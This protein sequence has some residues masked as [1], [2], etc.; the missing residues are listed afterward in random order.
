[1]KLEHVWFKGA[2]DAIN[3][4]LSNS[5]PSTILTLFSALLVTTEGF[6][7]VKF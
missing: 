6:G 2:T 5:G 4:L 3:A 7:V 1:V